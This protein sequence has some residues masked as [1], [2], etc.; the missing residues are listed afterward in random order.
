M[1]GRPAG[2]E[3]DP[4]PFTACLPLSL[5]CI[6][7]IKPVKN[8]LKKDYNLTGLEILSPLPVASRGSGSLMS[9]RVNPLHSAFHDSN[10]GCFGCRASHGAMKTFKL[11][12]RLKEC[13][14]LHISWV[15]VLVLT[16]S[17]LKVTS[18]ALAVLQTGIST[19]IFTE[20]C[21]LISEISAVICCSWR[22]EESY[23]E[24][25]ESIK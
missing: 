18:A 4:W 14:N 1:S 7:P 20:I 3:S 6:H 22:N 16:W 8:I 19:F 2:V 11:L 13:I 25:E 21:P 9:T 17:Q 5:P 24:A 15:K 10:S 23:V 12:S